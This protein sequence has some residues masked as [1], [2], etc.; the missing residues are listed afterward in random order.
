VLLAFVA[1]GSV[2]TLASDTLPVIQFSIKPRLCVLSEG[3]ALCQDELEI[4]WTSQT[5]RSICLHQSDTSAPLQCWADALVGEHHINISASQN[6]N[7]Q[8]KEMENKILLV[9]EA[10][11]VVHDNT[12]FRR[13]RRNAWSFF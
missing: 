7:F 4:K 2:E 12:K 3:E 1:G 6:I 13:R 11:E 9:T 10:F 5:P 8:L